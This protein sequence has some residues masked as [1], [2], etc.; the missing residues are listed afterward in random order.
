MKKLLIIILLFVGCDRYESI[1]KKT[2]MNKWSGEIEYLQPQGDWINQ[3]IVDKRANLDMMLAEQDLIKEENE[4]YI[5]DEDEYEVS[6][7]WRDGENSPYIKVK[8][9]SEKFDIAKVVIDVNVHGNKT[10]TLKAFRKYRCY[11]EGTYDRNMPAQS[12]ISHTISCYGD[13]FEFNANIHTWYIK[14]TKVLG[15]PIKDE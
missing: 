15:V 8:N 7:S 4:Y 10:E 11:K 2:R 3:D 12:I 6:G 9:I 13:E 5:L 14:D 1:D